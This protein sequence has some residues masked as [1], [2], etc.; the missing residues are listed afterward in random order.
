MNAE[1]QHILK[2]LIDKAN[3][4]KWTSYGG[5]PWQTYSCCIPESEPR[6]F[7]RL[8]SYCSKN[9]VEYGFD[10][11]DGCSVDNKILISIMD[12]DNLR[13]LVSELY[14]KVE[15]SFT[16]KENKYID[17]KVNDIMMCLE[18]I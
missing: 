11:H 10:M 2:A 1:C 4:I 9:G 15:A 17:D 12:K 6:Y 18:K 16:K 13:F 8:L 3:K 14:L 7:I 5:S